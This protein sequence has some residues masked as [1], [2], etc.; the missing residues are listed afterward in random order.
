MDVD[1]SP[2][3]RSFR[4]SNKRKRDKS[5]Q[6]RPKIAGPTADRYAQ[7]VFDQQ[8]KSNVVPSLSGSSLSRPHGYSSASSPDP[9]SKMRLNHV[10]L[11]RPSILPAVRLEAF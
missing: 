3:T 11:V 7:L 9:I 10:K 2:S 4:P 5:E 6:K 8:S 1:A